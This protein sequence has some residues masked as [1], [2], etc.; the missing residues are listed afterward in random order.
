MT[1]GTSDLVT[2]QRLRA[3]FEPR[4]IA[5][6]GASENSGWCRAVADNLR[7]VGYPADRFFPVHP[8]RERAFGRAAFR[9]LRDLPEPVE[10]A[11]VVAPPHAL[12]SVLDD[13]GAAGVRSVIV[14]AAGYREAGPEGAAAEAA[15]VEAAVRNDVTLLGPNGLG[16]LNLRAAA[17][18]CS[19]AMGAPPPPGP[20]SVLLHSG[21]L[22]GA[23]LDFTRAHGCG[24]GFVASMGN[25]A[26]VTTADVLDYLIE[27]PGTEVIALF[28]EGVRDAARFREQARRA[29]AAGKPV[30]AMKVGTSPGGQAAA[31]SHT[32]AL[33]GDDA[34]A[35]AAFRQFGVA[36][37]DSLE[38]LL[39]T[40][41]AFAAGGRPRGRRL[42]VVTSSGGAND[43]I[44]DLAHREGL[45]IEEFSERTRRTLA[46]HLPP[47]AS[48]GNPLD[49]TA[50]GLANGAV[51]PRGPVEQ[52]LE[53]VVDDPNLDL[54]LYLGPNVPQAEPSSAAARAAVGDRV[55]DAAATIARSP[56]PVY[57]V[58]FTCTDAGGYGLSLL[59]GAG[60]HVLAGLDLGMK[61]IGHVVR[62]QDKRTAVLPAPAPSAASF[63]G[64]IT[65]SG[66]RSVLGEPGA[67]RPSELTA[68]RLLELGGVPVVPAE[69]AAGPTAADVDALDEIGER[70]GYPLAVKVCSPDIAHKSDIGGVVLGVDTPEALRDAVARVLAAGESVPDAGVLGALVSP[71]RPAGGTELIAG[72]TRDPVFGLVL[73]VGLGGVFTEVMRDVAHRLLPATPADVAEMLTE[74]TG[75]ALLR[76]ARGTV[77][78]DLDVLTGVITRLGDLALAMDA[79][80]G[81]RFAAI[82]VNP[83]HV[84]GARVEALDALV[85]LAAPSGGAGIARTADVTDVRD[86]SRTLGMSRRPPA[87]RRP[88]ARAARRAE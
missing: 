84:H 74:L 79:G 30:V 86:M 88:R 5:L 4:S 3:L 58:S 16:Y 77:P 44:S 32:G 53:V 2:P 39:V 75:F 25:E 69:L 66:V 28:L 7:A 27:D 83:L 55:R 65:A 48:P 73:T 46:G 49:V 20:V 76:G 85:V 52:A 24:V 59:A 22:A 43:I 50:F 37:C 57:P 64:R 42:G 10:V 18:P 67:R 47:F 9:S 31:A 12:E 8:K 78:A 34:V 11:F 35:G 63:S 60:L 26:M 62:W 80:L 38:E 36:R 56:V 45:A 15:L 71:M 29:L 19:L 72:V 54:V 61:A 70:L 82:E 33:A 81:P 1:Q 41:G 51:M 14:L 68:R 87:R 17:A 6:V 23:V 40:A 21:R 13:A